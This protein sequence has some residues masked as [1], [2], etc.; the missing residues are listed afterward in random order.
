MQT[1]WDVHHAPNWLISVYIRRQSTVSIK[2][3]IAILAVWFLRQWHNSHCNVKAATGNPEMNNH[4]CGPIKLYLQN[5]EV[6]WLASGLDSSKPWFRYASTSPDA[7]SPLPHIIRVINKRYHLSSLIVAIR[8]CKFY[9]LYIK[10]KSTEYS[11]YGKRT[12]D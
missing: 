12:R 5:L 6:E 11:L 3:Q 10:I 7:R 4:A 9:I 2:G 8:A 1:F